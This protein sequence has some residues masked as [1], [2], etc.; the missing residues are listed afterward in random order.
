M[1]C[2]QN[3][4]LFPEGVL[5]LEVPRFEDARGFF[6]EL[7]NQAHLPET[8]PPFVQDNVSLSTQVGVLRGLHFQ[9]PPFAQ[10]KLLTVIQ[11]AI[12]DVIVDLRAK[13][14]TFGKAYAFHLSSE[15]KKQLYVPEGFAHG[16]LTQMPH[17]L[18]HYKVTAP[19]QPT[20]DSGIAWDSPALAIDWGLHDSPI[21][22]AK[23]AQLPPFNP[24]AS[25]F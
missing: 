15:N 14:P 17:T 3:S 16:F 6:S 9:T 18:V 24:E 1:P 12:L 8:L 7:Y 20:H 2:I 21:L 13:S 19:Y 10:G 25:Y 5:L 22:S 11:G 4:A 23:D